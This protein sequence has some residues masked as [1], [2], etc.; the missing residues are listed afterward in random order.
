MWL[1]LLLNIGFAGLGYRLVDLQVLRHQ[2]L[3][4]KAQQNTQRE[5]LLEPRRGDILDVTGNP[6]ATSVFVKTV[7]ASPQFIGTHPAEVA[8]SLSPLLQMDEARLTQLLTPRV[9][10]NPKGETVTNKYVRL[11]QK[12]SL[13]TWEKIH[14]AMTNLSFGINE[15]KLPN[16]ERTFYRT[17]RENA[18]VARNDQLRAYPNQSLAAHVLGYA[19]SE[20]MEIDDFQVTQIVGKEGIERTLDS[21]LAGVRGWRLTETDRQKRELV[22]LREQDVE[23]RD[24]LNVVL[25]IDSVIQHI[26]ESSLAE[27]M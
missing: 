19:T 22:T 4:A 9:Y 11:K 13:E 2:E 21:K 25:S 5:F 8:H 24:G 14:C 20:D 6:L 1:G 18:I 16:S 10:L 3:S 15:Q 12:V 26:V 7:C 27:A 23:P 17:L